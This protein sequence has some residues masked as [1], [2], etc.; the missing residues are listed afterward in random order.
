MIP[1]QGST[2]HPTKCQ[3]LMFRRDLWAELGTKGS[4]LRRERS[5]IVRL[6]V[7]RR[8]HTWLTWCWSEE[9][10]MGSEPSAQRSASVP[11]RTCAPRGRCPPGARG[12]SCTSWTET[13]ADPSVV[14]AT[15]W[16]AR[17]ACSG[18]G[19]SHGQQRPAL[20]GDASC[21][22][23]QASYSPPSLMELQPLPFI[24]LVAWAWPVS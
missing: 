13:E 5:Y 24:H 6:L 14:P 1:A 4:G 3:L 23:S 2:Q 22:T 8:T 17:Q 10:V 20:T 12:G 16:M 9:A 18:Q 7:P 11:G 21:R 15:L 19:G